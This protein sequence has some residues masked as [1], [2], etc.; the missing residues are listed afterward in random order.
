MDPQ[1]M[2]FFGLALVV[3][4]VS[5]TSGT[6]RTSSTRLHSSGNSRRYGESKS[7]RW[8]RERREDPD[9][10]G[11]RKP[12]A[13]CVDIPQT[14]SLCR[15]IGYLKMR[16]PNLLEHKTLTEVQR[17]AASW[18]SLLSSRCNAN[19]QLFLCSLFSPVCL[20][21]TIWPCRS[22]CLEV[23]RDCEARMASRGYPW[24]EM[25]NCGKFPSDHDLCIG[26]QSNRSNNQQHSGFVR[27]KGTAALGRYFNN[28]SVTS[29]HK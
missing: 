28:T 24:P 6:N 5:V 17:E 15:G 18:T 14:M 27:D 3:L 29:R 8:L 11:L 16:L 20:D 21:Q 12:K 7:Y 26:I 2:L 22:L 23:K 25:L 19:T 13:K 1:W 10:D 9:N 4:D